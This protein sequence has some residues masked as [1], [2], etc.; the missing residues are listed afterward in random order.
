MK[1]DPNHLQILSAIIESGGL[2]EGAAALNKSQP[3][4]SRTVAALEARL[5]FRLFEKGK[6]PLRP[7]ELCLSLAEQ[8]RIIAQAGERAGQAVNQ[9]SGG[10]SGMARIAGTPIFMDGVIA[11][12]IASFQGAFP[13]VTFQ[14]SYGYLDDLAE[15]LNAGRIDLAICPVRPDAVPENLTFKPLLRGRNVIACSPAH[16]LARKSAFNLEDISTFPWIAPPAGSPLYADLRAAL[17]TIGISDFRVS[18]TGGSLASILSIIA[19]SDSLTVLPYSVVFMQ[20]HTNLVTTLP[21]KLEHPERALGLVWHKDRPMRP[22][23]SRFRR[24]LEH[25]FQGLANQIEQKGRAAVW[26]S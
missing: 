25:E 6:R 17:D 20:S 24:Y 26:R 9:Y 2:S 1:I 11:N 5:G 19:G 4:V 12:M 18:F 10:K 22:A 21:V 8:G 13:Q 15:Q 7:T 3:S 16:P 23:V 14:Q